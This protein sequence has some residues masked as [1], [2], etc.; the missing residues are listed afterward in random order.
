M[1]VAM[2]KC[3]CVAAK[4][5]KKGDKHKPKCDEC[6]QLEKVKHDKCEVW[7]CVPKRVSRKKKIPAK[8]EC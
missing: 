1:E 8:T 4:C 2:D 7:E 6:H 5:V 3:N